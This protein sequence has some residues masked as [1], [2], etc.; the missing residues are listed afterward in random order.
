MFC[1]VKNESDR[2]EH[3]STGW[4]KLN[5]TKFVRVGSSR[6]FWATDLEVSYVSNRNR[7]RNRK[8]IKIPFREN[9]RRG[10]QAEKQK[11]QNINKCRRSPTGSYEYGQNTGRS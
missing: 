7:G 10:V 4:F 8:S 3:I 9:F 5:S 11:G 6:R 1:L 2:G